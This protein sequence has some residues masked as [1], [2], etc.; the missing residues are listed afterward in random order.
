MLA[1]VQLRRLPGRRGRKLT[2]VNSSHA[3]GTKDGVLV[4]AVLGSVTDARVRML[5]PL[6]AH[7]Y[8][9][10]CAAARVPSPP[11]SRTAVAVRPG[12]HRDFLPRRV[13]A[14][15]PASTV[16]T[17]AQQLQDAAANQEVEEEEA[18]AP[19][20]SSFR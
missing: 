19:S 6:R 17:D 18:P 8:P 4:L 16:H 15:A 1:P 10:D 12:P 13:V 7:G 14:G 9:R 2:G 5:S 20:R 3:G 11:A